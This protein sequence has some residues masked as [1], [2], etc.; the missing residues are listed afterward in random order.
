MCNGFSLVGK[1]PESGV[2]KRK[3]RPAS[4]L[5]EDL[6][7]CA[8]RARAALIASVQPADNPVVDTG[9]LSATQK[10]VAAG[11]VTG[12]VDPG[13]LPHDATLTRRFGVI[14]EEADGAPKVRP[15][16]DYRA[17]HVNDSV[18]QSEQVPVH[19]L[20]VVAAMISGWIRL[21]KDVGGVQDMTAKCWDLHAAYKQLPLDDAAY[22]RDGFFV[23]Y[24]P[25]SKMPEIYRQLVL[26]FGSKASVTAFIRAAFALWRIGLKCLRL[27]W[28]FYFDDFLNIASKCEE[29]HLELVISVFFRLLG[30]KLSSDKLLPYHVC[31][32]VLG[33]ELDL[34]DARLGLAVMRN[35]A[36]RREELIL[37]LESVLKA[38][39]LGHREAERLRGRLQFASGQLF[40][41]L[42]RHAI[43]ALTRRGSSSGLSEKLQWALSFLI[44][45]LKQGKPREISCNLQ[46]SRFVFVDASFEEG[47]QAGLGGL[48]YDSSGNI[49]K[50]FSCAVPEIFTK[51][52]Q[53]CFGWQ[54]ETVIYELEAL[55]VPLAL[56]L[57][58][59]E[60][61]SRSIA[62][63]T[64]NE[65]VH[66][67]FVKCW[68][69]NPVGSAL[70]Y[71]TGLKELSLQS[72][73][74]YDRVPSHSNPAD[75]PSRGDTSLPEASRA[76]VSKGMLE[77]LL[78]AALA[79]T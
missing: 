56:D 68:S 23:P 21:A 59:A 24:N 20:D 5:E 66:G 7:S 62:I 33:I 27:V 4:L 1:L 12:P 13:S 38:Q 8:S 10:E 49:L 72:V 54:R 64:D 32:K 60:L 25:L 51:V 39:C 69:E 35:T 2:F 34:S 11:F 71:L 26:P 22:S 15:I 42:A 28:S 74:Y 3:F 48:V 58:R 40:G 67:S 37:A 61:T 79:S 14:Q 47:G 31:C 52:L 63:F 78:S 18:S 17:S 70:A 53:T 50:W 45:L 55:A 75:K 9:V 46:S 30:W 76:Q 29:K 16:D 57:F 19:S 65:G 41:R 6:R 44:D 36:K 77:A 43:H 73:F